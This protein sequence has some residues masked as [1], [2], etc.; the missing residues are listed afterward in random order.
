M[1]IIELL[2]T[3]LSLAMDAFT[4][5]ICK[6]LCDNKN[7]FKNALITSIFFGLFQLIMPII[8]FYLGNIFT[9]KIIYYNPYISTI[10][11]IIIG[12][13]IFKEENYE[14]ESN[15]NYKELF[16]L[17]ISTSIDALFIGIS[18]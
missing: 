12:I 7:K 14:I 4:V 18:L 1:T 2:L 8:G 17:S 13:L 5:S 3:S 15:L 10:L 9:E 6:G 11:L 16:I